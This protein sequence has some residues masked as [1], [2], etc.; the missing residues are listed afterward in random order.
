MHQKNMTTLLQTLESIAGD[1][2]GLKIQKP[3]P[4]DATRKEM[5]A[6]KKEMSKIFKIVLQTVQ[7]EGTVDENLKLAA[8]SLDE[9]RKT[10]GGEEIVDDGLK[11]LISQYKCVENRVIKR[12]LLGEIAKQLSYSSVLRLVDASVSRYE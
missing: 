10:L 11:N 8:G 4:K 1:D 5:T 7:P 2:I 12:A 6:A 3:L 9:L